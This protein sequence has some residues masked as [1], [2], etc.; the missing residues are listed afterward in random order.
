MA[1]WRLL[2]P[3]ATLAQRVAQKRLL[4]LVAL[5]PGIGIALGYFVLLP[6][7][8]R[9]FTG[10]EPAQ[11][12]FLPQEAVVMRSAMEVLLLTVV[13]VE[14]P[15]FVAGLRGSRRPRRA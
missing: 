3:D 7:Y 2:M 11:L 4:G 9:I 15:V 8:Y 13:A 10:L 14:L 1:G 6:W 12:H 5:L